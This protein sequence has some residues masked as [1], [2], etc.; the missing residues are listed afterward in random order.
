MLEVLR[1][2]AISVLSDICC[3][4]LND[5]FG[6]FYCLTAGAQ[7][8]QLGQ[9]SEVL[10]ETLAACDEPGTG[11][12]HTQWLCSLVQFNAVQYMHVFMLIY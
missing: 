6:Y 7:A 3:Q 12:L 9:C 10:Y 11:P 8:E 5:N 4:S 1:T 2:A